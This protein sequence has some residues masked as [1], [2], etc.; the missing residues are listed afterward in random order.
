MTMM[1]DE[2]DELV[3]VNI[4]FQFSC[5]SL[6]SFG[7]RAKVPLLRKEE[8]EEEEG[9]QRYYSFVAQNTSVL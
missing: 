7:Q 9:R 1:I 6:R 3:I 5:S 2:N 4:F 8:E